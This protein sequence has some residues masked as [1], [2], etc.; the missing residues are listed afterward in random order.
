MVRKQNEDA[1]LTIRQF[2]AV[3]DGM[4]GHASGRVASALAIPLSKIF[5]PDGV[6]PMERWPFDLDSTSPQGRQ[7]LI[8][9]QVANL[10]IYNRSQVDD[11]CE[12]MGTTVVV[13]QYDTTT[14][15]VSSPG[16]SRC[17]RIR[18]AP[19]KSSPMTIHWLV[20]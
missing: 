13:A 17:Y 19:S 1:L 14:V 12:G 4:G 9:V 3:A 15:S 8:I 5:S 7:P 6:G 11:A 16:D 10:R 18:K 2:W 20:S